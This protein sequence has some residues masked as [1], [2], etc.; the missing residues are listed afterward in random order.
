MQL[1]YH[2]DKLLIL[3]STGLLGSSLVRCSQVFGY[4]VYTHSLR[5]KANYQADLTNFKEI[6]ILI[7]KLK[8]KVIVNLV[9]LTDVDFC[10]L[11]PNKAYL[12]NVR[13][14]ENLVAAI[15]ESSPLS[16][17]IHISTDQVYDG[18]GLHVEQNI[19][20]TNYYAFSKYA[21]ELCASASK[22]T[23]LRTNFFGRS[24]SKGRVSIT[25]WIFESLISKKSIQVFD[26]VLFSPLSIS[27]LSEMIMLCA[28]EKPV[29]IFNLGSHEGMSKADF[30]LAFANFIGLS[31][32]FMSRANTSEAH[33]LK[34]YRPKDM[35][36]NLLAFEERMSIKLPELIDEINLVAEE[37]YESA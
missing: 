19:S 16:H 15:K 6:N 23:I 28:Q 33:F 13:S 9:A 18:P 30:A 1:N 21:S 7:K 8:P 29:G 14:I 37:Y 34:T 35:R 17:L 2:H 31:T 25:D 32:E 22:A 12:L 36:M 10:E 3:G 4:D 26:D 24:L 11:H 27:T 20:L 5:N